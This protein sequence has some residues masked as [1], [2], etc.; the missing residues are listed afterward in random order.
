MEKK[1]SINFHKIR[2]ISGTWATEE[3][4]R[5]LVIIRSL[6]AAGRAILLD[7]ASVGGSESYPTIS[8]LFYLLIYLSIYFLFIY[9]HEVR[10]K[11]H[12]KEKKEHIYIGAHIN[13]Y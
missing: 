5:F 13:A 6:E 7:A 1:Y 2:Y 4:I 8:G 11:V 9:V 3:T 12:A 10:T